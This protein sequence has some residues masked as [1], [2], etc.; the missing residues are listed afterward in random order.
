MGFVRFFSEVKGFKFNRKRKASEW[1]KKVLAEEGKTL[2]SV[3]VIFC[4]DTY[5]V[6]INEQYLKHNTF[7]DIITFDL[8]A[9]PD[10]IEG[11][12]YISIDRVNENSLEFGSDFDTELHR[13]IIHGILHLSGYN[14][15]TSRQKSTMRE[16]EDAS[17]SLRN[18]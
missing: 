12:I 16:K 1:I 9:H 13:V 15:K 17:L 2:S 8:S 11:E 5:L 14:D 3:N 10:V 4:S 18:A 6:E 7:T